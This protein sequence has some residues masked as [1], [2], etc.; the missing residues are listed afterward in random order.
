M[1][2][3]VWFGVSIF[4][5]VYAQMVRGRKSAIWW[6]LTAI[7]YAGV[8]IAARLAE[9]PEN[10]D[11]A[12]VTPDGLDPDLTIALTA[13]LVAGITMVTVVSLFPRQKRS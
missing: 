12:S 13:A 6:V 1:A 3:L 7:I 9:G 8:W 10:P 5:G 11:L 4:V 2:I